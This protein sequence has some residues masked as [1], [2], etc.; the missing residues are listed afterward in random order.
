MG[1]WF[2]KTAAEISEARQRGWE[3]RR[4]K[5]GKSGHAGIYERGP[6]YH[7]VRDEKRL[8]RM[9]AV[10]LNDGLLSEGQVAKIAEMDRIEVRRY[11]DEGMMCLSYR[12]LLGDWG[13]ACMKRIQT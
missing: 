4:A 8:A 10:A 5:Y 1:R 12:P 13:A 3:T 9:I 2:K 11:R 7:V 6:R